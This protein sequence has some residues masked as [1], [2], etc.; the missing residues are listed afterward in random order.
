MS[1]KPKTSNIQAN[2]LARTLPSDEIHLPQWDTLLESILQMSCTASGAIILGAKPGTGRTTFISKL[3]E[4]GRRNADV[5]KVT[6]AMPISDHGWLLE[7]V[8]QWLS[9][10]TPNIASIQKKLSNLADIQRPLL[11]CVDGAEFISS[12]VLADD[13]GAF[14]NLTDNCG[15]R[16]MI[17]IAT[18]TQQQQTLVSEKSLAGKILFHGQV[19]VFQPNQV[20]QFLINKTNK[21]G[22]DFAH[23]KLS[24]LEIISNHCHGSPSLAI[25]KLVA[26][27]GIEIPDYSE[28][29]TESNRPTH[30]HA[31]QTSSIKTSNVHM[32]EDLLP[33]SS[34][35]K[36]R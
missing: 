12:N 16:A 15:L 24:D 8:T 28:S 14:L 10:E 36:V 4:A 2:L 23:P 29:I 35:K 30:E 32:L 11:I 5:I 13:V 17:V 1:A 31:K 9:S 34:H 20:L 26:L 6:P 33:K 21:I 19:P 3:C 25:R 18:S 7:A 22:S 27:M